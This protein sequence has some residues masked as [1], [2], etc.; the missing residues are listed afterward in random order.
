MN[1]IL[2]LDRDGII[3]IDKGFVASLED[4]EFHPDIFKLCHFFQEKGYKIIVVTNQTGIGCGLY[5]LDDF[6]CVNR[7]ML[8]EFKKRNIQ[9]LD[10]YYCPHN[11]KA[12]CDCRKPKPKM[13]LD[14]LKKYDGD[15]SNSIMIGDKI[16]D[17]MA[18]YMA[19]IRNL[20][21]LKEN[22]RPADLGFNYSIVSKL[23]EIWE[24]F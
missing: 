1:K 21:F 14:A 2:F 10:V 12:N 18:G 7:Y 19:N 22:Y 24:C 5:T 4:F 17:V 20:F 3:N 8:E 23:S 9:I 13:I 15:P 11:P 6:L 16:S